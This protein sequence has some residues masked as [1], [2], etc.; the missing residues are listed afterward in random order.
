VISYTLCGDIGSGAR[1]DPS[2][3]F[4]ALTRQVDAVM[5]R[6]GVRRVSL[7]GVSFG[8]CVALSYAARNPERVSHLIVASSPGPGWRPTAQQAAHVER[9]WLSLPAVAATALGRMG[10]EVV[11][12]LPNRGARTAFALRF[13]AT[14]VRFPALPHLM[15]RRVRLLQDLDLAGDCARITAPTLVITGEPALDSVVPVASTKEYVNQIH[16]ARYAMMD[17]TGHLGS[18]TQ[19]DRFARIVGEFVN[20]SSS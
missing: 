5:E 19:P 13:A 7:C 8:G 18:L 17:R 1:M 16:G 11:S 15:A 2:H 12:A 20:A 3:G 14:A 10:R 4:E 6:V 9:P